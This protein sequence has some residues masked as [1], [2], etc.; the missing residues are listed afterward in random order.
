LRYFNAAGA[1]PD[2]S[3]GERHDPETHLIPLVLRVAADRLSHIS[4]FGDDYPTPDGTCIRDY[5]HVS[6]LCEAHLLS[7]QRLASGGESS[8]YNLGNG[9]GFSVRQVIDAAERITGQRIPVK[10]A[11]RRAGDP[12][13][14]VAD[15]AKAAR[16][17][18][19]RPCRADLETIIADAWRWEQRRR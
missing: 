9:H 11:P 3:L 15:S 10:N 12:P 6:D 8:A 16:E 19:W 4:V 13:R 2:G 18:D 1:A 14:L 17:L 7:L 5:I